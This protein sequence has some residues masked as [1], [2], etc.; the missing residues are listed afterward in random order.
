MSDE[1]DSPQIKRQ[2]AQAV[3]TA[4]V[5]G[6]IALAIFATFFGSAVVGR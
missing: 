4:W 1:R 3:K 2:R 6:F 5:L